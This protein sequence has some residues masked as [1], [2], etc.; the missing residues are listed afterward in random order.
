MTASAGANN[1]AFIQGQA[2]M[3]AAN[4]ISVRTGDGSTEI[5]AD[6]TILATGSEPIELSGIRFDGQVVISSKE[7]LSLPEIPGSL[8]I[9]GGGVIGCELACVY[10]AMGTEV[11]IIEALERLVPMED[12]W[13][14][15]IIQREFKKLGI[16]VLTA[17][18]V[19]SVDKTGG[20]GKVV[21]E[22]GRSVEAE[23]VLVAVGRRSAIN[24]QIVE[25]LGL[26]MNGQSVA[27]NNRLETSVPGVYAIG[28][29]VGTT[30]LAHGATAEANV[31]AENATGGD[32]TMGDYGLIPRVIF[33]FPEIASVGKSERS[34]QSE[35]L[36]I[37]VGKGFF[38]ANGRS[39]AQNETVGQVRVIRDKAANK[40]V[41]VTI[42]GFMATELV[43]LAGALIGTDG[44][45]D[46]LTYPHPT[47]CETIEEAIEDAFG[48]A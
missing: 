48:G 42:V 33:T 9:I 22:D 40:V 15:R 43:S 38:K 18:K 28:D 27:I 4:R 45:L 12:E 3:P 29:L 1:I 34:C 21:L 2:T 5:E 16:E 7:A 13:V 46:E 26:E 20:R 37:T 6:K 14:A 39:V 41:G 11:T 10:A 25:S 17:S 32:R 19:S 30:F 8:A 24:A 47:I 35:G 44:R 36:E 23:K 31:A